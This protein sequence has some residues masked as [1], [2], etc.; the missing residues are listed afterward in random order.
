MLDCRDV[1]VGTPFTLDICKC[2]FQMDLYSSTWLAISRNGPSVVIKAITAAAAVA[3][4]AA[5][6]DCNS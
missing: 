1:G 4:G 2:A 3:A 5:H 6:K